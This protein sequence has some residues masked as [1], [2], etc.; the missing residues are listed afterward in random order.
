MKFVSLVIPIVL[1]FVVSYA[2]FKRVKIYDSFAKGAAKGLRAVY[3]VFPYL[4]AIFVMTELFSQSGISCKF[5]AFISPVFSFLGIPS[6]IAPLVVLKPFSGGGSLAM[7]SDIYAKYGV[8]NFISLCASA[9]YGSSETIFY[10]SAVYFS[11]VKEKKLA[12]PILISL[13]S[14][15]ISTVFA[16]FI[17]RLFY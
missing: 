5:I 10:I 14:T 3:S 6:E 11:E 7:L 17:C 4:V 9:V 8:D 16:C 2:V 1:L 12:K 15:L 13:S